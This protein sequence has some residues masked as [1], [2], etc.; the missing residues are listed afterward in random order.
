MA[1]RLALWDGKWLEKKVSGRSSWDSRLSVGTSVL[2]LVMVGS[3]TAKPREVTPSVDLGSGPM[4]AACGYVC[5]GP[6]LFPGLSL[7][8]DRDFHLWV[9]GGEIG[10]LMYL[11]VL[12]HLIFCNS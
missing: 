9:V 12:Y 11:S 1:L 7:F 3:A 8:W 10:S 4:L 5:W 2:G 6:L